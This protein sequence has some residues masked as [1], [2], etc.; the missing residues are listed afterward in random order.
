MTARDAGPVTPTMELCADFRFEAAHRLPHVPPE[1]MCA[2]MHGHSYQVRLT[3]V[4]PVDHHTGWVVDFAEIVAAFEPLRLQL[5]HRC[6]NEIAGLDNPTSEVLACWMWERLRPVLPQLR[7]VE[8]KE[9]PQLG[10]VY[11]GPPSI[12]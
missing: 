7:A 11:R 4:G 2:R 8:V 6:L 3:I 1:H 12:V 9:M 5:D 10:C